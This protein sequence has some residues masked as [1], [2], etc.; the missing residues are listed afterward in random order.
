MPYVIPYIVW[1][2]ES[3]GTYLGTVSAGT[4]ISLAASA[5][6]SALSYQQQQKE[7]HDARKALKGVRDLTVRSTVAPQQII[8]GE[9]RVSGPLVY[10]NV[11]HSAG[12]TNNTDF[13]AVVALA[14]HEVS[15][16]R[17]VWIDNTFVANGQINWGTDG[18][19]NA[20]DF[21]TVSGPVA[22]FFRAFG[23]ATQTAISYLTT[24]FSADLTSDFRGRG[25]AYIVVRLILADDSKA[26]FT[27]QPNNIHVLVRGKKV[28]DPRRDSTSP[29]YSGSGAQTLGS[30][31]TYEYSSNPAL[32][33]VDYLL[34]TNLGY[35]ADV[36]SI[37]WN[38]VATAA[39]HCDTLVAEPGSTTAKRF[40][41]NGTLF[42]TDEYRSNINVMLSAMN[43]TMSWVNGKYRIRA[44]M[45]ESGTIA[46]TG[47]DIVDVLTI[48]PTLDASQRYNS[49]RGLYLD[50]ANS[51]QERESQTQTSTAAVAREGGAVLPLDLSLLMTNS[52]YMVQRLAYK[53]LLQSDLQLTATFQMNMRA[54]LIAVGDRFTVTLDEYNWGAR[55]FRCIAWKYEVD[56]GFLVTG[57]V[58]DSGAYA[59][60]APSDYHAPS[61][62]TSS[63]TAG[64]PGG[65][66]GIASLAAVHSGGGIIALTWTSSSMSVYPL[67]STIIYRS[68]ANLFS[69]ASIIAFAYGTSYNDN[70]GTTGVTY[71]YWAEEQ[72]VLT[73]GTSP[74]FPSA[75]TTTV[76]AVS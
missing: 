45:Y 69:G 24:N 70:T 63:L 62:V 38:Y 11:C 43:G 67:R 57:I 21:M 8:Y 9:T 14:G 25:I 6:L 22:Q 75:T 61:L 49:V 55:V 39:D 7:A 54:L 20:G 59:D 26:I 40:T 66:P 46:F 17:D 29:Y 35:S 28:Y 47:D 3:I 74:P 44:G 71:Y 73:Y 31:S 18:Y 48:Y 5:A 34:D 10:A 42:A 2:V 76:T 16:I 52:E 36:S 56:K 65:P 60:P 68:T 13:C 1:A 19:V 23:T 4:W 64:S 37:P 15:D 30:P 33:L 27:N 72:N 58:D 12:S 32:C 53:K 50:P 51:Y 41:L